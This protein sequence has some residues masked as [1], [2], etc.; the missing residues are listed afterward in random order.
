MSFS[1]E[2]LAAFLEVVDISFFLSMVE[3]SQTVF[4]NATVFQSVPTPCS[5]IPKN[6]YKIM[7]VFNVVLLE[8]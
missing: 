6:P 3:S 7:L 1:Q 8:G 5:H 2:M 4:T